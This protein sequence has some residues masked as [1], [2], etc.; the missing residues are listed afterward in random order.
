[1]N[2]TIRIGDI[3]YSRCDIVVSPANSGLYHG[4]GAAR[5]I[6]RAAGDQLVFDCQE[7]IRVHD[8]LDIATPLITASGL[9]GP[10][11]KHVLHIVGPNME[12]EPFKSEPLLAQTAVYDCF[13]A[14]LQAAD[15]MEGV[16]SIAMPAISAGI[17]G[18]DAWSVSREAFKALLDFDKNTAGSKGDLNSVE[19]VCLDLS[20]AD[21]LNV[22]FRQGLPPSKTSTND[23]G[24]D[25]NFADPHA[26]ED[27]P[28]VEDIP[29]PS[30]PEND[31][32]DIAPPEPARRTVTEAAPAD[33]TPEGSNVPPADNGSQWYEVKRIIR[34]KRKSGK[35][36]YLV[37]WA[38]SPTNTWVE[39][40]D[41]TDYAIQACYASRPP[42]RR[43][44]RRNY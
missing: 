11:V 9:L 3:V 24:E 14:C 22:V 6:A 12:D 31:D 27:Y 2:V 10:T 39:K 13:S 1:M 20:V 18:M 5:A 42:K 28:A 16:T 37:E 35:D 43:R 23:L 34:T 8:K 44:R 32:D 36:L 15:H 33:E 40:K 19:F 29:G 38:D 41:L 7:Y 17:F 4:D 21:V 26:C 25:E 30:T